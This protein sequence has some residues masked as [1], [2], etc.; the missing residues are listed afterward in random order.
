LV[1]V[2]VPQPDH[3]RPAGHRG[4]SLS[5][6][7][8][9]QDAHRPWPTPEDQHAPLPFDCT[10][11]P[12][13]YYTRKALLAASKG[14]SQQFRQPFLHRSACAEKQLDGSLSICY[15]DTW[16]TPKLRPRPL[17]PAPGYPLVGCA[18]AQRLT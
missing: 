6:G 4:Q 16:L 5:I 18:G 17:L 9:G 1:A 8:E 7:R 11:C 12:L 10:A 14:G 15:A 3:R 2:E 13:A